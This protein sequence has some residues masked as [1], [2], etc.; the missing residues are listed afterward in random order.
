MVVIR[1]IKQDCFSGEEALISELWYTLVVG[2]LGV[3]IPIALIFLSL[4][5]SNNLESLGP[6][7]ECFTGL[8]GSGSLVDMSAMSLVLFVSLAHII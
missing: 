3:W 2:I 1:N 7:G 8:L 5:I 6:F 4:M